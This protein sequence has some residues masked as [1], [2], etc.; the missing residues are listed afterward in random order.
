M[1]FNSV[2]LKPNFQPIKLEI[3]IESQ[4]EFDAI[5]TM[6]RMNVSVP[7]SV[8]DREEERK[9]HDIIKEFLD[10]IRFQIEENL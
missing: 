1:N 5:H 2:K 7:K 3:A 6:S 8:F 10:G 4:E 9:E